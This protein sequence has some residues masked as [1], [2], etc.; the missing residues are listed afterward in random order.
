MASVGQLPVEIAL[1]VLRDLGIRD[2]AAVAA[3]CRGYHTL[4]NPL[5][6]KL[7][8]KNPESYAFY[9]AAGAGN[10]GRMQR[11]VDAGFD[12]NQVW[13]SP[14]SGPK[15]EDTQIAKLWCK[16]KLSTEAVAM[17]LGI[18]RKRHELQFR[19]A[20]LNNDLERYYPTEDIIYNDAC[21]VAHRKFPGFIGLSGQARGVVHAYW[22]AL[23]LAAAS[24]QDKAV[25]FLIER[26]ANI[27][28]PS[29]RFCV[30]PQVK[31]HVYSTDDSDPPLWSPLHVA[32]CRKRPQTAKLLLNRGA[33][34][35]VEVNGTSESEYKSNGISTD[36]ST[37][38]ADPNT[39][40]Q[41]Q[42]R[43]TALHVACFHGAFQLVKALIEDGHQSELEVKDRFGQTPLAYAF[44]A[45][46]FRLIMPYLLSKGC[47]INVTLGLEQEPTLEDP[48]Q[49]PE[50]SDQESEDPNIP[51]K[52]SPLIIPRKGSPLIMACEARRYKDAIELVKFGANVNCLDEISRDSPLLI[53]AK[54][55]HYCKLQKKRDELASTLIEAGARL[56]YGEKTPL[57]AAVLALNAGMAKIL[58]KHGADISYLPSDILHDISLSYI[59]RHDEGDAERYRYSKMIGI[60]ISLGIDVNARDDENYTVLHYVCDLGES[61]KMVTTIKELI[62]H[63]ANVTLRDRFGLLPFHRAF[64]RRRLSL[65]LELCRALF[66]DQ[67][68]TLFTGDDINDMFISLL[69]GMDSYTSKELFLFFDLL[70]DVG[71]R[72]LVSQPETLKMALDFGQ[73]WF[74]PLLIDQRT[75]TQFVTDSSETVLRRGC[76]SGLFER[77]TLIAELLESGVDFDAN[78]TDPDGNTLLFIYLG[79][80]LKRG[81]QGTS[82]ETLI[83]L[84]KEDADPHQIF[85]RICCDYYP[86]YS[87]C[88]RALDVIIEDCQFDRACDIVKNTS[89]MEKCRTQ[90]ETSGYSYLHR[91]C[92][93]Q[94]APAEERLIRYLLECGFDPND[95]SCFGETPLFHMLHTFNPGPPSKKSSCSRYTKPLYMAVDHVDKLMA[96]IKLLGD[97]GAKWNIRNKY[98]RHGRWTPID[99]LQ[100]LLSYNGQHHWSRSELNELEIWLEEQEWDVED[101]GEDFFLFKHDETEVLQS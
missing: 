79:V 74:A 41:D 42:R 99:E 84:F 9:A 15:F 88:E 86:D 5:L 43:C 17:H 96:C 59:W 49:E 95:I 4:A 7:E 21:R 65:K 82:S 38:T 80:C 60:L 45:G 22:T 67:L 98:P 76:Q 101:V 91:A 2:L 37:A 85:K 71:G 46:E 83:K 47:D 20:K 31:A 73:E 58:I 72:F 94:K 8:V 53:C 97:N 69:N 70:L 92:S 87:Q 19:Y 39:R 51:R 50:D 57:Y 6:Y 36:T 34:I 44:C 3:T 1:Q 90:D 23:H 28:A 61:T 56:D 54:Q 40:P 100:H 13:Y 75:F 27:D 18:R 35:V 32:I 77:S 12:V 66:S 14:I 16:G 24:G 63:G 25:C 55:K 29:K 64:R 11:F 78:T 93:F 81:W 62:S 33:S 10:V 30:C 26:G 52:R 68:R 48:E 89:I